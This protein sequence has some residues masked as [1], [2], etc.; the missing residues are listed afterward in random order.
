MGQHRRIAVRPRRHRPAPAADRRAGGVCPRQAPAP[1][2][3]RGFV[4][5]PARR[6]RKTVCRAEWRF[7]ESRRNTEPD[8]FQRPATRAAEGR[9]HGRS[10]RRDRT[11]LRRPRGPAFP[12]AQLRRP[13]DAFQPRSHPQL[14]QPGLPPGACLGKDRQIRS[15]GGIHLRRRPF[16]TGLPLPPNGTPGLLHRLSVTRD[17][18]QAKILAYTAERMRAKIASSEFTAVTDVPL[19]GTND[20]RRFVA[21]I[22]K[23]QGIEAVPV[24]SLAVWVNK[25]RPLIR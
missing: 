4:A 1:P 7:P 20:R 16:E 11:A 9:A 13:R 22:L 3:R 24:E 17:P 2:R 23:D 15:G 8:A 18:A 6:L 25:L 12:P 10:R 19:A 14:L 21:E 5:R